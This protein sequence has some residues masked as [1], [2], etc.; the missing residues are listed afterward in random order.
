MSMLGAITRQ[1]EGE[2]IIIYRRSSVENGEGRYIEF[3]KESDELTG[4]EWRRK[5]SAKRYFEEV[6]KK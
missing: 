5:D 6:E 4:K 1:Y 2:K 3:S